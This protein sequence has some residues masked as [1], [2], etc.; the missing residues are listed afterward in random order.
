MSREIHRHTRENLVYSC[1]VGITHWESREGE[2]PNSLPGAK[3]TMFFAPSQIQKRTADWGPKILQARLGDAWQSFLGV[4]DQWVTVVESSS[5]A[6][7]ESVF[8][9]VLSNPPPNRAYVLTQD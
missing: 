4:V 5:P 7:L 6:E 1:A 9:T 3:P 8:D 2:D